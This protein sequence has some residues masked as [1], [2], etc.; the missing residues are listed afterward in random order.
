MH[1]HRATSFFGLKYER[2]RTM[3]CKIGPVADQD[4]EYGIV[5]FLLNEY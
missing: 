3:N 4:H 2:A 1:V 5:Q